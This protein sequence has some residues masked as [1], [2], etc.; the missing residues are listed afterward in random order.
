MVRLNK[1]KLA[2]RSI[3]DYRSFFSTDE[4]KSLHALSA[5]LKG[6]RVIHVNAA[7]VGGGVA[8]ILKTLV[9]LQRDIGLRSDW[10]AI[11]A[12]KRF[13]VVTKEIHNGLQ[14][15]RFTL[16]RS[17]LAHYL[18]VNEKLAR[19]LAKIN[20]DV[21]VIH[22]PQPMAVIETFHS[23]RRKGRPPMISRTHIDL[24]AP[25]RRLLKF[26][27]PYLT[28]YEKT[29]FSLQSFVPR[30]LRRDQI[31]IIPPGIDP[32]NQ[33]NRVFPLAKAKKIIKD[34]GIDPKR[35]LMAQVSRFDPWKNPLGVVEAYRRATKEIPDLQL[36]LVGIRRAQDDPE[37]VKIF[38]EVQS[39]TQGDKDVFLFTSLD[40]LKGHANDA[41][42]NAV[43][44]GADVILQLSTREGFGL[45]ATEAMWKGASVIGG[46]AAGIRSQITDGV[47]GFIAKTP[48]VAAKRIVSLISDPALRRKIGRA[49]HASVR[50]KHLVTHQL[51]DHLRLYR[52][53]ING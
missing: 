19:E 37:A 24:S 27:K 4:Q 43:Q 20:F 26:L 34:V 13:F 46:P 16:K 29:V 49:A 6:K 45:T 14:G 42:V 30:G 36:A 17:D 35:P 39:A 53:A 15:K 32:L 12:P 38:H 40:Q 44:V 52:D 8:E 2:E 18:S 7:P 31:V 5:S 41:F 1:V 23:S 22:D 10:Y 48:K 28:A 3:R 11:E 50:R 51:L 9:P 21:A 25:D 47:D 33:K